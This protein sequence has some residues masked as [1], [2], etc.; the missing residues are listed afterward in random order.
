VNVKYEIHSFCYK[1]S[2]YSGLKSPTV[3]H[4][5]RHHQTVLSFSDMNLMP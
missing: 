3:T 4:Y 5:K 2:L 1:G